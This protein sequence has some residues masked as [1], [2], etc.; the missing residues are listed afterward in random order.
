[1]TSA[2]PTSPHAVRR[3]ALWNVLGTGLPLG[4]AFFFMPH[5][6]SEMGA[7]RFG[8]LTL[9][10]AILNYFGLFDLGI[11]RALTQILAG[12]T[13]SGG[14]A[15]DEKR[16]EAVLIWTVSA[17]L[18]LMGCAAGTILFMIAPWV[19]VKLMHI[20]GALV[21]ETTLALREL[22]LALPFLIHGLALKGI[23]EA[24]RRFDLSN[25]IRVPVVVFTF[26]VPFLVLPFSHDL[27][28][29]VLVML[30]GRI[31]AWLL[32]LG[33][34]F[35]ILPHLRHMRGWRPGNVRGLVRMGGWFTVTSVATPLLDNMD[36]FFI[37][38][39]LGI[40]MV[41]YF[42]T[43]YE[44]IVRLGIIS[45]GIGGAMFPEFAQRI[46][47]GPEHAAILFRRGFKYLLAILFPC[48]LLTTAYAH[49]GLALWLNTGFAD[50]SAPVLRWLSLF[51][52]VMG[53]S[54]VPFLFL[55]GVG[56]PD[57]SARM[58]L[59]ELP[60]HA[61]LLY[62]FIRM[63]GIRG[64]AIACVLRMLV[65]FFGMLYFSG[66]ILGFRASSYA[67]VLLPFA[68]CVGLLLV[69]HLSMTPLLKAGLV[70]AV[71]AVYSVALW[72][73]VLEQRDKAV[74]LRLLGVGRIG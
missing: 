54:V 35:K 36:R 72:S 18:L 15:G 37:S 3:N 57:L 9:I 5:L 55:G 13:G 67:R 59:I 31:F 8:V 21:P 10:L 61:G 34:V 48:V 14:N 2:V 43:P 38:A 25:I 39:L 73:K 71:L 70:L 22:A 29:I 65:D 17:V 49:E 50:N 42:T 66:R 68:V 53:A 63:D 64:A 58:H 23:L 12:F 32:N 52:F 6:I 46:K 69:F 40:S 16:E 11:G 28:V 20:E 30:C 19:T 62:V 24:K 74:V 56:R 1:M 26:G 60:L 33:M 44:V 4:V 7:D 47:Q 27:G 51:V 41:A 45:G